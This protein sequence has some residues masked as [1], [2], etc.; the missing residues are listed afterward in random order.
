MSWGYGSIKEMV[1]SGSFSI[2]GDAT[3]TCDGSLG[4]NHLIR[5]LTQTM[6]LTMH[7]FMVRYHE[8]GKSGC[9]S[10]GVKI[11]SKPTRGRIG[12]KASCPQRQPA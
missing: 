4:T 9:G 5:F 11:S 1:S 6:K 10:I 7:L 3:D 8:Y 12:T 2:F